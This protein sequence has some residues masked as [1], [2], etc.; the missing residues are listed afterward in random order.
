MSCDGMIHPTLSSHQRQ[1]TTQIW[2]TH[3]TIV[4]IVIGCYIYSVY[5][6]FVRELIKS[7]YDLQLTA[8]YYLT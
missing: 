8:P 5:I 1:L 3:N 7:P 6:T 2:P 4:S